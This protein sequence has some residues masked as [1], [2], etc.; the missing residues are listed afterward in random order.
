[1]V[2]ALKYLYKEGFNIIYTDYDY[3]GEGIYRNEKVNIELSS[4]KFGHW[5]SY[6]LDKLM[7]SLHLMIQF[8]YMILGKSNYNKTNANIL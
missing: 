1:M 8:K 2:E 6:Y 5:V 3:T 7:L 4:C